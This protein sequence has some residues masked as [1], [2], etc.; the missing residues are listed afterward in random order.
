LSPDSHCSGVAIETEDFG[1]RHPFEE[2]LQHL[3]VLERT[4]AWICEIN[5][6]VD[7]ISKHLVSLFRPSLPNFVARVGMKTS[8]SGGAAAPSSEKAANKARRDIGG[9][10]IGVAKRM[11]PR[12]A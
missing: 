11:A 9:A 1:C 12:T 2:W 7:G 5:R 4:R 3:M 10:D 6:F 8:D